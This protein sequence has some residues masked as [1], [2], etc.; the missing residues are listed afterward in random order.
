MDTIK[1]LFGK[2]N[3]LKLHWQTEFED[4]FV[5]LKANR[6]LNLE[7]EQEKE[8]YFSLKSKGFIDDDRQ[9]SFEIP[10]EDIFKLY[11]EQDENNPDELNYNEP[12]DDYLSFELPHVYDSTI[13]IRNEGN[14]LI[15][16]SVSYSY[17][18]EKGNYR[19][20]GKSAVLFDRNAVDKNDCYRL[21]PPVMYRLLRELDQYDGKAEMKENTADQFALLSQIKEYENDVA[22]TL[23]PRLKNEPKPVIIDKIS[24]DIMDDGESLSIVPVFSED[25]FTNSMLRQNCYLSDEIKDFYSP[26][27]GDSKGVKFV[28]RNREILEKI[29]NE[30]SGLKGEKRLEFLKQGALFFADW[31][32]DIED[33]IDL[34]LYSGRV[35]GIGYLDYKK[36]VSIDEPTELDWS[37]KSRTYDFPD[38]RAGEAKTTLDPNKHLKYF[39]EKEYELKK[40]EKENIEIE[41]ESDNGETYKTVLSKEDFLAEKRKIENSIIAPED[42]KSLQVLEDIV[43][44]YPTYENQDYIPL[45]DYG[46]YLR[47]MDGKARLEAS[48]NKLIQDKE[49]R[50]KRREEGGTTSKQISILIDENEEELK[51]SETSNVVEEVKLEIPGS[52]KDGI[53]LMDHQNEALLRFQRIWKG[54]R[55]EKGFM[56][57]DDMGLGKTLQILS[58]MAWLKEKT[59]ESIDSLIVAPKILLKNWRE[60]IRKFFKQGAFKVKTLDTKLKDISEFDGCDIILMTY[61]RLR[62]DSIELA[63]KRWKVFIC[64]EAQF[65]KEPKTLTTIASKGQQAEFK[66]VCT[67]TPIENSLKDLWNLVDFCK[68]GKLGCLKDF[69]KEYIKPLGKSDPENKKNI[70]EKLK[71][72]LN[73]IYLRREK[74][75][76]KKL[77]PKYIKV[78]KVKATRDEMDRI[79]LYYR[80]GNV[81]LGKIKKMIWACADPNLEVQRKDN[82]IVSS[83]LKALGK[84]L[85]K[86]KKNN[87][88]ALIFIES[89]EIQKKTAEFIFGSFNKNVDILNG[90]SKKNKEI[91]LDRFKNSNGF[92]VVILSPLVAGFG[93]TLTEANHVIHYTRMWNPAK[94]DQ[95]T[96]RTYRIGQ[97]KKVTVHL[98]I[99]TFGDEGD[100]EFE[101]PEEWIETTQN[102]LK[103]RKGILTPEEKLNILLA[104]K[105]NL[106]LDFFF[107]GCEEAFSNVSVKEFIELGSDGNHNE[108][109][110]TLEHLKKEQIKGYLFESLI[111]CLYEKKGFKTILTPKSNDHGVD[112]IAI[113]SQNQE[114][115][116]V[117]CKSGKSNLKEIRE[118]LDKGILEFYKSRSNGYELKKILASPEETKQFY[119]DIKIINAEELKK[120]LEMHKLTYQ[121]IILRNENRQ[122]LTGIVN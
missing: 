31:D 108:I 11:Y 85:N 79:Q 19:R 55:S 101:T 43:N 45:P 92:N 17:E 33:K 8:I 103:S 66:I 40:E 71:T 7:N 104:R 13:D 89:R 34:S 16:K 78:Y 51:Y 26:S 10:Y 61:D 106:L 6:G 21:I 44:H 37:E 68:P 67:A 95:A 58:F 59:G 75:R 4:D 22:L 5:L 36:S 56:L 112:V 65:I 53:K 80:L 30:C 87:E 94:E 111:A 63:K 117:Q 35:I 28:V 14:Y 102:E 105:K 39:I 48:L 97:D 32:E 109:K 1:N 83:K 82:R 41:L 119:E 70:N 81:P 120:L 93:L 50:K 118:K 100:Y 24:I 96:D 99:L 62:I 88:K 69:R 114:V 107:A 18:F 46:V 86:I 73:S 77:P 74:D 113:D 2:L 29:R 90:E 20:K 72:T 27:K 60:E 3:L 38:L 9:I 25:K 47:N 23:C 91:I 98:P 84:I 64:D 49:D 52:L 57:C 115:L 122:E 54:T 12:V 15:D 76:L 42:I 116:L 110:I 121:D